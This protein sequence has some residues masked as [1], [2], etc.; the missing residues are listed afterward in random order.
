MVGITMLIDLLDGFSHHSLYNEKKTLKKHLKL[1]SNAIWARFAIALFF[2][3]LDFY[4]YEATWTY[5]ATIFSFNLF[6]M[7]CDV[8]KLN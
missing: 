1:S 7:E 3:I 5:F 2:A 4:V 8:K 6:P